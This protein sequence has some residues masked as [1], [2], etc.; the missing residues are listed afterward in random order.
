[1]QLQKNKLFFIKQN[2]LYFIV[3]LLFILF[4]LSFTKSY[5]NTDKRKIIN[6]A[7]V[8]QKYKQEISKFE[9]TKDDNTLILEKIDDIWWI[10]DS[11]NSI[12]AD[13]TKIQN[14]LTDLIKVRKM[15]KISDKNS[16]K[17][18]YGVTDSSTFKVKYYYTNGQHEL[19]FGSQDFSQTSRYLM[20]DKNTIIYEIDS[21]L[22]IY[23]SCSEL[24]WC[25][26]YIISQNI[27]GN[28][29][30]EDIQNSKITDKQKLLNLRHGGFPN[31][32]T[33]LITK[34]EYQINLELGN[35]TNIQMEIFATNLESQYIVK[36]IYTNQYNKKYTTLTKISE[37]TYNTIKEITL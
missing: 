36:C 7:L 32:E 24:S 37:W 21:T 16:K 5:N 25:E 19:F 3:I 1:M 12:P 23:L 10:V 22:D 33:T 35:K 13:S 11:N 20:T 34:R 27:L 28:I 29:N 4:I 30:S 15:Y 14:L 18:A 17:A 26:P 2:I 8:N 6:T 9:F 31:F